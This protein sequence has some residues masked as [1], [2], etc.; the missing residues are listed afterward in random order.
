[1]AKLS[2]RRRGDGCTMTDGKVSVRQMSVECAGWEE[3]VGG[4]EKR[5]G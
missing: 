3:R 5:C 2:V 4:T 1:M